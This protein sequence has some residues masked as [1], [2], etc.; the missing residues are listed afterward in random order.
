MIGRVLHALPLVILLAVFGCGAVDPTPQ[1]ECQAQAY[2]EPTVRDL[3]MRS[4]GNTNTAHEL[5]PDLQDAE[6]A[7]TQR[8]LR[9][10]GLAPAG[11]VEKEQREH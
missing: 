10:R 4:L 9:A 2:D 7:A 5:L 6:R 11:G 1:G 8:C 3:R